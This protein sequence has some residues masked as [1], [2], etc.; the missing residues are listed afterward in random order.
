MFTAALGYVTLKTR[1]EMA[2]ILVVLYMYVGSKNAY[3]ALKGEVF[4][5]ILILRVP[6]V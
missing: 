3:Q 5:F 6:K 1:K 4:T 2:C